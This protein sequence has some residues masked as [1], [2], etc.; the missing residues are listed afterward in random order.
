MKT[1][2]RNILKLI[3]LTIA[4]LL[5][6]LFFIKDRVAQTSILGALHDKH[7]LLDATKDSKI[8]VLGGSNISFGLDSKVIENQL[9]IPVI[10]MGNHAGI[11]LEYIVNDI[12]PFVKKGDLIVLIPEY[13]HFYTDDFYG[14]ME[15]V[16]TVFEIEPQSKKL[17][18]TKQWM[19]LLKYLPTYS[20]KKLKNYASSLFNKET[21]L[22]DIYHRKSFNTYGDAYLHWTLPNQNY[23]HAPL[24][25]G[26]EK[27]NEEVIS[28]LKE[29]KFYTEKQGARLF[30]FPP[31]IDETS[32]NNKM[33]IITK[34]AK[35]L[36][37]NDIAFECEPRSF[38][39]N[40]SLFF[41]SY[42]HLNKIGVD[43][44]TQQLLKDLEQLKSE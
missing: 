8:M 11:G 44:R 31:V 18:N 23:I 29:F 9:N 27:V 28:F 7:K 39:Y 2:L 33:D 17:L 6:S 37:N 16:Q 26:D 15:L 21:E 30:I 24:L 35:E 22:I 20:A 38:C 13:E 25:K 36:K 10:N 12:K 4:V 43:K 40:D 42:Y 1:F 41:N 14:E 19:H 5:F 32:F 3:V 34:I